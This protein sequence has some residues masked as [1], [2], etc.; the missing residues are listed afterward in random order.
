VKGSGIIGAYHA[1]MVVPLMACMLPM[2]WMVP[3]APLEVTVLAEGPLANS[4][5][6]QHLKE[7]MESLKGSMETAIEFV[8]L[9]PRHP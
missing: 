9:V 7:A 1:R 6:T 8:Y 3:V 5:I 2:H 4:K